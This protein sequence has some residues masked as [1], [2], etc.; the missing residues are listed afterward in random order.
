[1][2]RVLLTV[3]SAV[4]L[5]VGAVAPAAAD[6]PVGW[7]QQPDISALDY[8]LVLLLIPL[9]LA[10]L[11]TVLTL[12]PSMARNRGYE[13]GHSWRGRSEWFGGPQKGV[14]AADE[15]TPE[16]LEAEGRGAGGGSGRW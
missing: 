6:T 1:M 9:G 15:V 13:P 10:L 5:V 3:T 2:R 11:I 12:I 16:R 14:R 8:L 4:T 7:D